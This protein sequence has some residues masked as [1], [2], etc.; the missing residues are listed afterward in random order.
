ME[1]P[2]PAA[3]AIE[4]LG[5]RWPGASGEVLILEQL[6]IERGERLF[7]EGP[8]GSGKSTLLGLL[9]GVHTPQRGTLEVLGTALETVSSA[10]RDHFRAHH[11]GYIFQLFNLIPYLSVVEN[12]TLPCR[13]SALRRERALRRF[14]TLEQ[15][16][17]HLL[18]HLDLSDPKLLQRPVTALSVGQQQRVA[19]ARALIGSPEL[20]IADEPTSAL[21]R[22]RCESFLALLFQECQESGTT[23]IFV[24]HDSG[25]E[26]LFDRTLRLAEM[27]RAN[28]RNL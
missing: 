25:L 24:S 12:V 13:F 18:G 28:W 1:Q 19:A 27:N 2:L 6:R 23:L 11:I 16:A 10:G 21:D 7:I 3:V 15:E 17:L 9:A 5:F 26:P 4:Q 22:D 20:L 14:A 8:S